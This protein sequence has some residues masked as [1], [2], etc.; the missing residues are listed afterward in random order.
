[1]IGGFSWWNNKLMLLD[2]PTS[3]AVVVIILSHVRMPLYSIIIWGPLITSS[4]K[5]H[6]TCYF[7]CKCW[8]GEEARSGQYSYYDYIIHFWKVRLSEVDEP[9][10]VDEYLQNMKYVFY[11][12]EPSDPN[13][14]EMFNGWKWKLGIST[15]HLHI[16]QMESFVFS[17][18]IS[19]SKSE[20]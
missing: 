19:I 16:I 4:I 17:N 2:S 5:Y 3:Q 12:S 14:L 20:D 18:P 13:V 15:S 7:G 8:T 1:M 6:I 10:R 9:V 11:K